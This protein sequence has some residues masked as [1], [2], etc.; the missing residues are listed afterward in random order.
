M[1]I[2]LGFFA[3]WEK[4]LE[5]KRKKMLAGCVF[6]GISLHRKCGWFG[7]VNWLWVVHFIKSHRAFVDLGSRLFSANESFF[8]LVFVMPIYRLCRD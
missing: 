4:L 2:M 1:Y 5:K 7:G 8:W 3:M 6:N